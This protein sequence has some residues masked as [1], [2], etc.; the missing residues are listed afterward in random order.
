MIPFFLCVS[1]KVCCC[2]NKWKLNNSFIKHKRGNGRSN[3]NH[4]MTPEYM[5]DYYAYPHLFEGEEQGQEEGG[6]KHV[7]YVNNG[8][9]ISRPQ[10]A[11]LRS[12]TSTVTGSVSTEAAVE[13][14]VKAS[15]AAQPE[16]EPHEDEA[17][18]FLNP[19]LDAGNS[20]QFASPVVDF[21]E[22]LTGMMGALA[23]IQKKGDS[24]L[25]SIRLWRIKC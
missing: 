12:S 21:D 16:A 15:D 11:H 7:T 2:C 13:A 25:G 6:F 10:S 1:H 22:T 20:D 14:A 3:D 17:L 9:V 4:D 18:V 8:A 19:L 23:E 5:Y 24:M